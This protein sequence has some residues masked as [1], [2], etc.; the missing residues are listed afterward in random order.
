MLADPLRVTRAH[1][2]S[3]GVYYD[4]LTFAHTGGHARDFRGDSFTFTTRLL[5]LSMIR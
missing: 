4:S 2:V 3:Y 5:R 1:R